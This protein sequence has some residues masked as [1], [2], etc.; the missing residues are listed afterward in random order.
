MNTI[1]NFIETLCSL[2]LMLLLYERDSLACPMVACTYVLDD[3]IV[4]LFMIDVIQSM[5]SVATCAH[6]HVHLRMICLSCLA[7]KCNSA[8]G[9]LLAT[10]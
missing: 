9:C 4:V 3:H 1:Q 8:L 7:E 2:S 5:Q 6:K 10:E